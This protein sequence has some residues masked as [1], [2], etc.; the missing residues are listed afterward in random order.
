MIAH[1]SFTRDIK[2]FDPQL[3][4]REN[5]ESTSWRDRFAICQP[6]KKLLL[7]DE[8]A[9]LYLYKTIMYPVLTIPQ[10]M[11]PD[12]RIIPAL[13]E[14]RFDRID[15]DFALDIVRG[16]RAAALKSAEEMAEEASDEMFYRWKKEFGGFN[17]ANV[18]NVDP[19]YAVKKLQDSLGRDINR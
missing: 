6:V 8:E 13:Y 14:A 19:T 12:N 5:P 15:N 17:M 9:G 10:V 2:L 18:A 7:V 16:E 1:P 4:V 3:E 11:E